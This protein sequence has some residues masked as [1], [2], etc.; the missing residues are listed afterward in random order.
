[1]AVKCA[2]GINLFWKIGFIT[3]LSIHSFSADFIPSVM[4]CIFSKRA[5]IADLHMG[6]WN[7]IYIVIAIDLLKI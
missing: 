2:F 4:H 7:A 6:D 5:K 1:M 3:E